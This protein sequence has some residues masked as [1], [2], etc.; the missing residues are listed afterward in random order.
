MQLLS[1]GSV[2]H[3]TYEVTFH[4]TERLRALARWSEVGVLEQRKKLPIEQAFAERVARLTEVF[5]RPVS[6]H[7]SSSVKF[8]RQ[9]SYLMDAFDALPERVDIAF[10]STWKAFELASTDM[11]DGNITDRLKSL[12]GTLDV[13]LTNRLCS[14]FPVQSCE[15]L[16]KRLVPD[17]AMA[18]TKLAN[19]KAKLDEAE[20]KIA[21]A[22]GAAE[23]KAAKAWEKAAKVDVNAAKADA[24]IRIENRVT[25]L[26]DAKIVQLLEHLRATYGDD[27]S[28][29]R[30]KG[31]LLLRKA[32]RGDVLDLGPVSGFCLDASSRS[33]VLIS[34]FLYT[35]RN[36]RFHGESF[37]PFVSSDASIRTY[38][39]PYFLF[40]ASYYLLLSVWKVS[41]PQVLSCD[42]AG[43][44]ASLEKNID[45]AMKL[46]GRHWDK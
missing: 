37:S 27:S 17:V 28:D 23:M 2:S 31:S 36:G 45:T 42:T 34:L 19:A 8:H 38:T 43:I 35:A 13:S 3:M 25:G 6:L 33:G 10:D 46:F 16:F 24:G 29:S 14:F 12:S 18:K 9:L 5:F 41:C 20:D 40:L 30:R 21:T 15:Y 1:F 22:V 4:R 11:N 7:D 26:N 39:H 44:T 32:L